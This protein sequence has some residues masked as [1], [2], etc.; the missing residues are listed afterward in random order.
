MSE[1]PGVQEP[2]K[3]SDWFSVEFDNFALIRTMTVTRDALDPKRQN[4][5]LMVVDLARQLVKERSTLWPEKRQDVHFGVEM[6]GA[7]VYAASDKDARGR[8]EEAAPINWKNQTIPVKPN[9]IAVY[10]VLRERVGE[11]LEKK[12]KRRTAG[13]EKRVSQGEM[14][15]LT[16]DS[17]GFE[18]KRKPGGTIDLK[19]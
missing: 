2:S 6:F 19:V 5:A 1:H 18:I 12:L 17:R 11:P 13:L 15:S 9:V 14:V 16:Y 10:K 4:L 3:F 7:A 8:F